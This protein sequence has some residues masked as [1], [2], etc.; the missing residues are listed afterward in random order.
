MDFFF[1]SHP[2]AYAVTPWLGVQIVKSECC[3]DTLGL[4]I[5]ID[6]LAWTV[7]VVI[8]LTKQS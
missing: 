4:C 6:F 3:D 7:G 8:P 5:F 2:L 1:T